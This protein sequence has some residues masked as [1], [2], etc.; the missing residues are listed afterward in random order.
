MKKL[1][2]TIKSFLETPLGKG[3]VTTVRNAVIAMAGLI[4]SDLI[5]LFTGADIDPTTKLIIIGA[6]KIVDE[7]LHK[8]GIAE[9]GITRF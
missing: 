7:G 3:I 8:T 2:K 9:K 4:V 1:L 5:T 6:L